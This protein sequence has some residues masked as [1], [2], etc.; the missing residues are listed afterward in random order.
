LADAP[1]EKRVRV[2]QV[3][4]ND[5]PVIAGDSVLPVD[6]TKVRKAP[7]ENEW[8]HPTRNSAM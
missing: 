7:D 3:S 5:P 4:Q 8:I 6:Q 2:H 1:E